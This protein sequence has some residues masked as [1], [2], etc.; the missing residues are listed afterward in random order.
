MFQ[1]IIK[2]NHRKQYNYDEFMTNRPYRK[3][4]IFL[5]V[6]ESMSNK[7][8]EFLQGGRVTFSGQVNNYKNIAQQI[9]RIIGNENS[10]ANYLSKCI[11][12]I[13]VGSN[14][15]LNNYFMP[16]YY[17]TSRQY[18]PQQYANVLIQQYTQ[19]LKVNLTIS[20]IFIYIYI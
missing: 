10:A 1:F 18:T 20:F 19:Q 15:Y 13:G 14:D 11:Y 5:N 6:S 9:V 7:F 16:Q 12:S 2:K 8:I 3:L 17:S 4:Y